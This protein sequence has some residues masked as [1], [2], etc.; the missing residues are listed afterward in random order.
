MEVKPKINPGY[1]GVYGQ[2]LF[3]GE[4]KQEAKIPD[5]LKKQMNLSDFT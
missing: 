1:D 4:V 5:G 3:D 2:V